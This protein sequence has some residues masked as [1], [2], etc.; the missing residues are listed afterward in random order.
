MTEECK[1]IIFNIFIGKPLAG[2]QWLVGTQTPILKTKKLTAALLS[3]WDYL[4]E[5]RIFAIISCLEYAKGKMTQAH[6]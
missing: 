4:K 6:S 3:F 1:I 5:L 2:F